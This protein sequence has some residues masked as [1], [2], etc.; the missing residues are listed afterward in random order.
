MGRPPFV[1]VAGAGSVQDAPPI[2][3]QGSHCLLH[4]KMIVIGIGIARGLTSQKDPGIKNMSILCWA[5]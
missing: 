1:S 5:C 4:D 2:L 3:G